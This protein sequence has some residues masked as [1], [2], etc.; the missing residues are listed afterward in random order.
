M[1]S[2][3]GWLRVWRANKVFARVA[4]G[5]DAEPAPATL[6]HAAR[7]PVTSSAHWEHVL[8]ITRDVLHEYTLP[9][10]SLTRL[11]DVPS[12]DGIVGAD[13]D[14]LRAIA[15]D[16]GSPVFA[17]RLS[18]AITAISCDVE[19]GL[20]FTAAGT[21]LAAWDV[22]AASG[23][24]FNVAKYGGTRA[25]VAGLAYDAL[26]NTLAVLDTTPVL[27]LFDAATGA[28]LD[29][30]TD[31]YGEV[32]LA[33]SSA[34]TIFRDPARTHQLD[35]SFLVA[36]GPVI[37]NIGLWELPRPLC[38]LVGEPALVSAEFAPPFADAPPLTFVHTDN[39]MLSLLDPAESYT[40]VGQYSLRSAIG[41]AAAAH[42]S[43]ALRGQDGSSLVLARDCISCVTCVEWAEHVIVGCSN[44]DVALFSWRFRNPVPPPPA[45]PYDLEQT[46]VYKTKTHRAATKCATLV[47]APRALCRKCHLVAEANE[48]S[49]SLAPLDS[50]DPVSDLVHH[51]S[52]LIPTISTADVS[53]PQS[54]PPKSLPPRNTSFSL[55]A[56]SSFIVRLRDR[57]NLSPPPDAGRVNS[58]GTATA[59]RFLDKLRQ[60]SDS[61]ADVSGGPMPISSR[62]KAQRTIADTRLRTSSHSSSHCS[63]RVSS[64]SS[65][66]SPRPPNSARSVNADTLSGARDRAMA[67]LTGATRFVSLD[68]TDTPSASHPSL[69]TIAPNSLESNGDDRPLPRF[70]S[71]SSS[72]S[73]PTR[74]SP[75]T[76]SCSPSAASPAG[77]TPTLYV[78]SASVTGRVF[79]WCK[80]CL[81]LLAALWPF[82]GGVTDSVVLAQPVSAP[83]RHEF[84][85]LLLSSSSLV[86]MVYIAP[87]GESLVAPV[88]TSLMRCLPVGE[89]VSAAL[90]WGGKNL[91]AGSSSGRVVVVGLVF[92][93]DRVMVT[94]P[95][96]ETIMPGARPVLSVDVCASTAHAM[97][98]DAR[99]LS[100]I[101]VRSGDILRTLPLNIPVLSAYYLDVAEHIALVTI[102]GLLLV[103]PHHFSS[104]SHLLRAAEGIPDPSSDAAVEADPLFRKLPSR[105]IA[106]DLYNKL[107]ELAYTRSVTHSSFGTIDA[108]AVFLAHPLTCSTNDLFRKWETRSVFGPHIRS[109]ASTLGVGVSIDDL[110][111]LDRWAIKATAE[112]PP[113]APS[114]IAT[115]VD[116][117]DADA[118]MERLGLVAPVVDTV[119]SIY[120]LDSANVTPRSSLPLR[121][122]RA[123]PPLESQDKPSLTV[124]EL[125]SSMSPDAGRSTSPHRPSPSVVSLHQ[126]TPHARKLPQ[127]HSSASPTFVPARASSPTSPASPSR[128]RLDRC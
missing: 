118:A 117:D 111:K 72:S 61:L 69:A 47:A 39:D 78:F 81:Q 91:I 31:L 84:P 40:L 41:G 48:S 22:V 28:E 65:V 34:V 10:R 42:S 70:V 23:A 43:S 16:T 113:S 73:S 74:A 4:Q 49:P 56:S 122:R 9:C 93:A 58:L 50:P 80:R 127:L 27:H 119:A 107:Y 29:A 25:S 67:S 82:G 97:V 102:R 79:V 89:S 109:G 120:G 21:A 85:F 94:Q 6:S 99:H 63:S 32:N 51:P 8:V 125:V 108:S 123:R 59:T 12:I 124:A 75:V 57:G 38:E 45:L 90:A 20:I 64:L 92:M 7:L 128:P 2:S 121:P 44:G 46:A 100:I 106:A 37:Y 112:A 95:R 98:L 19:T 24:V 36:C 17:V 35:V 33:L 11:A 30:R 54:P 66:V 104:C 87:D 110:S 88:P 114:H 116:S 13:G 115:I 77:A 55:K 126:S 105:V 103:Y 26:T 15:V 52:S 60:A 1:V 101:N 76:I 14:T 86:S 96:M 68:S 53:R 83:E 62:L 71:A 3:D 18:G 5:P